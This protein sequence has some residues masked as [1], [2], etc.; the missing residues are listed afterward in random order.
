MHS[1]ACGGRSGFGS[2]SPTLSSLT[3]RCGVIESQPVR[4]TLGVPGWTL[5][6]E[7]GNAATGSVAVEI[8]AGPTITAST[9]AK[10]GHGQTVQV[11][12]VVA[13]LTSDT[14]TL[15]TTAPGKGTLSLP[16]NTLIYAAPDAGG[17]DSIGYTITDQL[18][19][20]VTGV[21]ALAVDSGPIAVFGVLTIGYGQTASL[22]ALLGSLVTPGLAGD[23]ETII[24]I[25]ASAGKATLNAGAVTYAAPASGIDTVIYTIMDQLG[26]T[27]TGAVAVTVDKGPALTSA[28]PARLGHGK[29]VQVATV[30]AGLSGDTLT[31]TTTGGRGVLSLANGFISYTAP[32]TG[33]AD[34][35]A[36][37][38]ADQLGDTVSGAVALTV[39]GGPVVTASAPAKVGHGKSVQVGAVATGLAG[40][41][42][43]LTT[44]TPGKGTLSLA[45]GVI[46]YAAPAAGGA[47][48]IGYAITD[49]LGDTVTGTV[50]LLVDGGPVAAAVTLKVVHG[51]TSSLTSFVIGLVTPGLA[52]D[53]ETITAVSAVR[54]KV[55]LAAG[56]ITYAAPNSGTD[57][58]SFTVT[59][60][61]GEAATSTVA[62]SVDAG[63][64]IT[65]AAPVKVGH[66]K[67]V[68][69]ASVAAGL[70][71]DTLSLTT[72]S[73]GKGTLGLIDGAII[74]T[75]PTTGGADSITYT[76]TD[77]L[78]EG[79][80]RTVELT[81]DGGPTLT[82]S[83]PAKVGHGKTMQV[84]TATAGLSGDTLT[85][86][87]T[88]PGRGTLGLAN[89]VLNYVAPTTGGADSVGYTISDQ[90]GDTVV[91]TL[92]LIVDAG[93]VA[94][95]GVLKTGHG[96]TSSLTVLVTGLIT[97]GLSGDAETIEAVSAGK[98]KATLKAGAVSYVAP[99]SGTDTVTFTATD[100]L[101]ET[102]TGT[103]AVTID[104]G[105]KITATVPS[106][107]GHGNSV[108]VATVATGL[109]GDTL[110][111]A[112]TTAGKG[113]LSLVNGVIIYVA[114]AVGGQDSIAY[115]VTDQLG[116]T[117]IGSVT[118]AIDGGPMLTPAIPARVGHADLA[119][120]QSSTQYWMCHV[121][122]N[123]DVV[124]VVTSKVEIIL[125]RDGSI[126]HNP[127]V[128]EPRCL[129]FRADIV[130]DHQLF[131]ATT[132]PSSL[133]CS[134]RFWIEYKKPFL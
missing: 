59:D 109:A 117:V 108:A 118:L 106:K 48:S 22:T 28:V 47:D 96:Q 98:G 26:E 12:A 55:T 72:T 6:D 35:L 2:R 23:T 17:P 70:T 101:G 73:A 76:I 25:S 124:D 78:G 3:N 62:V 63:P 133:F 27:A 46:S 54:G 49:Q 11:G 83:A 115:T 56:A 5:T 20:T 39:D 87:T 113:T 30:T 95:A 68:Q 36:Y 19:E 18:G 74:Y 104:A 128:S 121:L 81:V 85:L 112:T 37:T 15:A 123:L 119:R 100:Q 103:I 131:R 89:G 29:T 91:G 52:G 82:T 80:T 84:G 45:N 126:A 13:G 66:G 129:N 58:V 86:T 32:A 134:Q 97:P 14:L 107:V 132:I 24:A 38:V 44:T 94:A 7:A 33:G 90:L 53:T 9:P 77:Q 93:P 1:A 114:P 50:A 16:N 122:P 110:T 40:D 99:A 42:L 67:T 88:T 60:Q 57:T 64:K 41:T 65:A 102:V 125:L 31:L 111:L 120:G 21:V 51:Q 4:E 130:G 43:T 127:S 105:P 92:A 79:A 71:G 75:A 61:L 10:V 34:S 116:D 69:V 8:D